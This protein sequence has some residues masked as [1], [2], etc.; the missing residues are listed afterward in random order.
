[1]QEKLRAPIAAFCFVF[2]GV[3][4]AHR[5]MIT[6]QKKGKWEVEVLSSQAVLAVREDK[7]TPMSREERAELEEQYQPEEVDEEEPEQQDDEEEE[8]DEELLSCEGY[9]I[10]PG[11]TMK[12]RGIKKKAKMNGT[13]VE[14][15]KLNLAR[16]EWKVELPD[17][18]K[19]S[20]P[21]MNLR[22]VQ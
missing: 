7:L 2:P 15:L 14:V 21:G 17:G 11:D 12:L 8:Y 10:E 9:I 6:S 16:K 4:K 5:A 20:V 22:H 19:M 3:E 13:I 18:S 1:M